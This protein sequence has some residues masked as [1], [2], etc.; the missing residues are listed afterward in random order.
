MI[1]ISNNLSLLLNGFLV[2]QIARN[3]ELIKFFR[4]ISHPLIRKYRYI[5]HNEDEEDI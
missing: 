3:P 5:I 4:K 2:K 1:T